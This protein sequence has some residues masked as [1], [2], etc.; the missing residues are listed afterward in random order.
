MSLKI[1]KIKF[2]L[3]KNTVFL[4]LIRNFRVSTRS[5]S[6][7]N[8]PTKQPTITFS[9]YNNNY[10]K[11]SKIYYIFDILKSSRPSKNP[12]YRR[13]FNTLQYYARANYFNFDTSKIKNT[14]IFY[15]NINNSIIFSRPRKQL[16]LMFFKFKPI[17]IFTG[18]LMRLVMNEKKKSAKKLFK[19]AIS[20]IK[21]F[22]ILLAKRHF[23][24]KG[25]LRLLNI[26]NLRLKILNSITKN[27]LTFK[28]N[29][30]II[31]FKTDFTSQKFETRRSV[32]KYVKKRFKIR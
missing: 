28:I 10:I 21:L 16:F 8:N 25:Y 4:N 27:K 17:F 6:K 12:N 5:L 23:F 31:K 29:Y 15:E 1:K 3:R 9:Y 26:G 2:R 13:A 20:L 30:I 7:F 19:V 22:S 32:K 11:L 24:N 18:G 14:P